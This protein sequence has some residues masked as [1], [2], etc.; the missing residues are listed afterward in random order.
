MVSVV[1]FLIGGGLSLPR[2]LP[3]A[4]P[5]PVMDASAAEAADLDRFP[6]CWVAEACEEAGRSYLSSLRLQMFAQRWLHRDPVWQ[7]TVA[8]AERVHAIWLQLV[9]IHYH[10]GAGQVD[11]GLDA[12]EELR[13][14]LGEERWWQG[15]MP[16]AVPI[17][18]FRRVGR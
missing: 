15:R 9:V 17:W 16:P 7:A 10:I 1:V 13:E 8:D 2:G 14:L 18:R 5:A 3:E 4:I 12:M 11:W 6:C